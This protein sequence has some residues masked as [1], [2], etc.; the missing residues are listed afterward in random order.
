MTMNTTE[1]KSLGMFRKDLKQHNACAKILDEVIQKIIENK[2]RQ[3][4]PA[5]KRSIKEDLL[6]RRN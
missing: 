5:S 6:K 2:V 3:Q 4:A 1:L